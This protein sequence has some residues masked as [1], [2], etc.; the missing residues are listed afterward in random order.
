MAMANIQ[1]NR[2]FNVNR[3]V[4]L[5]YW[6]GQDFTLNSDS[7]I[8]LAPGGYIQYSLV[9][10]ALNSATYRLFEAEFEGTVPEVTNIANKQ[11]VEFIMQMKYYDDNNRICFERFTIPF[12]KESSTFVSEDEQTGLSTYT[13]EKVVQCTEVDS[14]Y[15]TCIV[16]NNT[17]SDVKIKKL[18]LKQSQD[19]QASQVANSLNYQAR[20]QS[21]TLYTNGMDLYY[22]GYDEPVVLTRSEDSQGNFNGV[23][24]GANNEQFIPCDRRDFNR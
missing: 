4:S 11:A 9:Y 22:Y 19:L 17:Q 15:I 16:K 23:Y 3:L 18:S 20:L 1:T 7:T 10:Q 12:T 13:I 21:V 2:T 5:P 6:T 8:T 14:Q 24:V